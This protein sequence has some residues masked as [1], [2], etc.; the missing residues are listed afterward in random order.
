MYEIRE[1]VIVIDEEGKI[2]SFNLFAEDLFGYSTDEVIDQSLD[3][4]MKSEDSV[5]YITK[6]LETRDKKC[7]DTAQIVKAVKKDGTEFSIRL[8]ITEVHLNGSLL[9]TGIVVPIDDKDEIYHT[10]M[11]ENLKDIKTLTRKLKNG[12][13]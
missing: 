1:G 2:Q 7:A 9:F 10:K 11:T 6:C 4:L 12:K 5:C 13:F 8:S 3:M